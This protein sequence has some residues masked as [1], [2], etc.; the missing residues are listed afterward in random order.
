MKGKYRIFYI[1]PEIAPFINSSANANISGSLPK[2]LKNLGHDIRVMMPKYG[3]V[4]ERKYILR[5]VIRL[6]DMSIN[7]ADKSYSVNAKSAFLPDSKV[8]V[9]FL[10]H[11]QFSE[12]DGI[13]ADASTNLTY[14]DNIDRFVLFNYG[15]VQTIRNLHWRPDIIICNNWPSIFFP[16]ILR[17]EL[18]QDEFFKNARIIFC[19]HGECRNVELDLEKILNAGL[20]AVK[21]DEYKVTSDKVGVYNIAKFACNAIIYSKQKNGLDDLDSFE[22][23]IS[24]GIDYQD[25]NPEGDEKIAEKFSPEKIHLKTENKKIVCED[26]NLEYDEDTPLA[27]MVVDDEEQADKLTDLLEIFK[28]LN[29]QVIIVGDSSVRILDS[30]NKEVDKQVRLKIDPS[31]KVKH[32]I[33]AGA[34]LCLLLNQES[35]TIES[36]FLQNLKYG[37]IGV[38]PEDLIEG[39]KPETRKILDNLPLWGKY[40]SGEMKTLQATLDALIKE[41]KDHDKWQKS[42]QEAMK[43]DFSLMK[44]GEQYTNLFNS[45]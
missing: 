18:N 15:C 11:P 6:R 8:Q 24:H 44:S 3:V 17:H 14:E 1:T 30:M 39:F 25:W 45:L 33:V 29:L 9:Y 13:Y 31:I 40:N 27:M 12:R 20:P 35:G 26:F 2:I 23:F 21:K 10:D 32:Q 19:D 41:Y 28:K 22:Q 36:R 4:N 7:F 43:I 37:A 16:L 34:D 42:I 38:I 5:D